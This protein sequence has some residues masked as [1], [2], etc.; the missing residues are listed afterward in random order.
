MSAQFR[1]HVDIQFPSEYLNSMLMRKYPSSPQ[2][3][4]NVSV[5]SLVISTIPHLTLF[6]D[7]K[8]YRILS[9]YVLPFINLLF[10]IYPTNKILWVLAI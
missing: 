8:Q 7:H 9:W 5:M 3:Y 10:D 2:H 4:L 6:S 1:I